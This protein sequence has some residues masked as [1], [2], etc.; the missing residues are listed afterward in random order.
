MTKCLFYIL[1]ILLM[2][3]P[4]HAQIGGGM[5]GGGDGATYETIDRLEANRLIAP[6][7]HPTWKTHSEIKLEALIESI[8]EE[9]KLPKGHLKAKI[10]EKI[11]SNSLKG[12]MK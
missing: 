9:L 10:E 8:E 4:V 3:V 1:T 12:G 6:K 5:F 7:I 11:N 2:A